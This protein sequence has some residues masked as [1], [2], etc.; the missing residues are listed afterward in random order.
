MIDHLKK[1]VS[2]YRYQQEHGELRP[3]FTFHYC[4]VV[5]VSATSDTAGKLTIG[6]GVLSACE[7]TY[8]WAVFL[9]TVTTRHYS[10]PRQ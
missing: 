10:A 2:K 5:A 3:L 9:N 1:N 7:L 4:T 8:N 6:Q